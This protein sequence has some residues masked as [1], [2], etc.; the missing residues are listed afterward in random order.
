MEKPEKSDLYNPNNKNPSR[1]N[2]NPNRNNN[3]GKGKGP[4]YKSKKFK[5]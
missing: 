5:P 4:D 3:N 2:K 1:N